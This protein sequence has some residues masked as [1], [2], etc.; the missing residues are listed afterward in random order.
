MPFNGHKFELDGII[1]LLF[2]YINSKMKL[3][4][5]ASLSRKVLISSIRQLAPYLIIGPRR[6]VLIGAIAAVALAIIFYPLIVQTPFDPE[7]VAIQLTG[8]ELSSGSESEQ[9]LDLRVALQITNTNE[10]T[11]TTS[12]IAYDLFADGAPVGSDTIS[13]EDVP[14]TGR[15]AL[16]SN[17]PVTISDTLT[18]QY[19]DETASLFSRILNNSTDINWRISG[20]ATIESGTTLQEKR[21][22]S[23]I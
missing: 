4:K 6:L 15:P 7:K 1:G 3:N 9:R 23:E 12:R 22:S 13:Y 5:I 8:V 11:L 18:L 20:S 2:L 10:F 19:T 21:F 14:V 17:Q 16:F